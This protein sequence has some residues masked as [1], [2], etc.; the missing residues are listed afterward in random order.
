MI[1]DI[2]AQSV[3]QTLAYSSPVEWCRAATAHRC[4]AIPRDLV[5]LEAGLLPLNVQELQLSLGDAA[6]GGFVH[7]VYA[8][9]FRGQEPNKRDSKHPKY[10]P[11][12]RAVSGGHRHIVRLLLSQ[13]ASA[14]LRDRL[15]FSALHFAA[16]QPVGI[17]S[18]LI[19]AECEVNAV[20]MQG[21]TPLHSAAGMGRADVCKLLLEAGARVTDKHGLSPVV[22]A[23]RAADRRIAAERET[24]LELVELLKQ[25]E[26]AQPDEADQEK[27]WCFRATGDGVDKHREAWLPYD[28]E[29]AKQL[30]DA[31]LGGQTELF[32]TSVSNVQ[33]HVNLDQMTQ[34]NVETGIVRPIALR[35]PTTSSDA[36]WNPIVPGHWDGLVCTGAGREL[37][38][39]YTHLRPV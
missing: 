8:H 35:R 27:T 34:T 38:S 18:D 15:G 22:M 13:G 19:R 1:L 12:H 20:N 6:R 25:A 28:P 24:L 39:G 2:P 30:E 3:C 11:L 36:G 7:L 23:Q 9:L 21:I 32:V 14:T 5:L 33:Y 4:F 10:T 29:A 17:A 16:N 37:P 26:A 31:R